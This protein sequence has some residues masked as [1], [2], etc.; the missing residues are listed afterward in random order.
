M[1]HPYQLHAGGARMWRRTKPYARAHL[2]SRAGLI[3]S[4]AHR[5]PFV[6]IIPNFILIAKAPWTCLSCQGFQVHAVFF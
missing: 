1:V 3:V 6:E 5:I 2:F 4:L